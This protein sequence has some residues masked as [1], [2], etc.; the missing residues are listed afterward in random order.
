M[1]HDQAIIIAV[2]G[3]YIDFDINTPGIKGTFTLGGILVVPA[4]RGTLPSA[5]CVF[6]RRETGGKPLASCK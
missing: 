6:I 2:C 5:C 3:I 4:R 1:M